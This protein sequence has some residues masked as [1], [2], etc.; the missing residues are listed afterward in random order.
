MIN[1]ELV[2][3]YLIFLKLKLQLLP[4]SLH[5]FCV[6]SSYFFLLYPDPHCECGT[7]STALLPLVAV[8]IGISLH[9]I[10]AG[11]VD[12]I[13][14]A[15]SERPGAAKKEWEPVAEE[16]PPARGSGF[17]STDIR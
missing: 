3:I 11:Y 15:P 4:I 7:G 14:V 5:F 9:D 13:P 2:Q 10:R 16:P 1:I 8:N 12:Q 6:F 17:S